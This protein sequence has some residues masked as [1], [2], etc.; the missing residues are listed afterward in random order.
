MPGTLTPTQMYDQ[1]FNGLKGW[2]LPAPLDKTAALDSTVSGLVRRRAVYLDPTATTPTFLMGG[3]ANT[4]VCFA[5]QGQNELD[6]NS[7]VGNISGGNISGLSCLGTFELEVS[8]Y[9]DGNDYAPNT[10]L[11]VHTVAGDD[12]AKLTE[13]AFYT[14][15]IVGIVS[16]GVLADAYGVDR[17]RF[18][19]Y[20]LPETA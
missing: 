4:P 20:F 9:V 15:T 13:G 3:P 19:T 5:I 14:D 2:P 6:A 7:D 18:W 17:L 11:T 16:D 8:E 10:P 1:A 12:F